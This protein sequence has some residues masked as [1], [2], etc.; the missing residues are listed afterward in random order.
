MEEDALRLYRS[1]FGQVSVL[2]AETSLVTHA[3]DTAH[4]VVWLDGTPGEMT[5]GGSVER[6]GPA[7]AATINPYEPHS[8]AFSTH[9]GGLF[10]AFYVDMQWIREGLGIGGDTLAFDS[11][12][13][14]LNP[15]Q[16]SAA[17]RIL[18]YLR[19]ASGEES[20]VAYEIERFLESLIRSDR[21]EPTCRSRTPTTSDYRVRKAV[22]FMKSNVAERICFDE[23]ARNVGLSRPHFFALFKEQM[24][25]TPNIYWN[26]LRTEEAARQLERTDES[27][28]AVACNLGFSTQGNFSRFFREH[29][30]VPPR[31]Y[32]TAARSMA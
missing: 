19:D 31:T 26:S 30:G 12:F 25:M 21:R 9:D 22:K 13:V 5:V 11:P 6:L 17:T 27:L 4:V 10:L 28:I 32:R 7:M 29:V 24:N 3:H 23:L 18:A 16:Y 8:H 20:L 14:T 2:N 1:T 15:T